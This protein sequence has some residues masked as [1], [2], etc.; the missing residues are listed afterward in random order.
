MDAEALRGMI[1][2]WYGNRYPAGWLP[3]RGG[4]KWLV[5]RAD[6]A[7]NRA[8]CWSWPVVVK[9]LFPPMTFLA[10]ALLPAFLE[11]FRQDQQPTARIQGAIAVQ[12]KLH[13]ALSICWRRHW[14][15]LSLK[16]K[17]VATFRQTLTPALASRHF[18]TRGRTAGDAS[19]SESRSV[20]PTTTKSL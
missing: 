8:G 1:L 19:I 15:W 20:T 12:R 11:G 2:D 5:G 13:G 6:R 10:P 14:H 16:L 9:A 7:G 3:G 4:G 18:V 17:L